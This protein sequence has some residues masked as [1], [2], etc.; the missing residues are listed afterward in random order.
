[1]KD[2]RK[3]LWTIS[4]KDRVAVIPRANQLQI[5]L[6]GWEALMRHTH[7]YFLLQRE[8]FTEG[9]TPKIERSAASGHYHVTITMPRAAPLLERVALQALLG[10][11]LTR[12]TYNYVRVKRHAKIPVVFFEERKHE[13]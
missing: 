13:R 11:D 7:T 6:D 10:S 5:D 1:M 8:G 9:W 3:G 12:E 2:K 4:R